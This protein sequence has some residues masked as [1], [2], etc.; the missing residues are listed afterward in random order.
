LVVDDEYDAAL[1][2]KAILEEEE[3][4]VDV[5]ND[6]KLALSNFKTGCYHLLILDILMPKMNGFEFYRE[7]RK[8][9]AKVK[10]CFFTASEA[11]YMNLK[12]KYNNLT[13]LNSVI[14]KP[15]SMDDLVKR[16]NQIIY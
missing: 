10:A 9:D 13:D 8:I 7:I 3:F 5:F 1:T 4:E 12:T 15:I 14:S 16:V 6:P 11:Y 2:L